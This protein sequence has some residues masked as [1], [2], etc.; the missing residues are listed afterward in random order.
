[1]TPEEQKLFDFLSSQYLKIRLLEDGTFIGLSDLLYTR[2]IFM[3][4]THWGYGRRFCFEDRELASR[5]FEKLKTGEQEPV[6]FIA[7]R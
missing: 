3:D 7:R 6:G 2:A 4:M 5:E 1:M